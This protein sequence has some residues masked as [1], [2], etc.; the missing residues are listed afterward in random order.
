VLL[1]MPSVGLRLAS[2]QPSDTTWPETEVVH[3]APAKAF[4]F[5]A[6][7]AGTILSII[8]LIFTEE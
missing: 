4:A 1:L 5:M 3:L 2:N 8:A 6:H 7:Y